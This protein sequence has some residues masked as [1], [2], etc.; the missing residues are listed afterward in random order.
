MTA[1]H[2][3]LEKA[4]K[5]IDELSGKTVMI[6]NGTIHNNT[7]INNNNII[8]NKFGNENVAYI[9]EK[10]VADA[11][12]DPIAGSGKLLQ[13]VH[14]NEDH[15]ENHNVCLIN[16]KGPYIK[17]HNGNTWEYQPMDAAIH[18]MLKKPMDL[19]DDYSWECSNEKAVERFAEIFDEYSRKD[20]ELM[21]KLSMHAVM[22]LMNGRRAA[23]GRDSVDA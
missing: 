17:V 5:K 7:V 1:M 4:Q 12:K 23:S 19:L 9:S 13:H 20:P 6:N 14:C 11:F 2:T 8:I 22:A 15:P 10:M 18:T 16:K 21:K 3:A